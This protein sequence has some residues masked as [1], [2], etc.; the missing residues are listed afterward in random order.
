MEWV[1]ILLLS[2]GSVSLP[3]SFHSEEECL[4]AGEKAL[5]SCTATLGLF[6]RVQEVCSVRRYVCVAQPRALASPPRHR[7]PS[8]AR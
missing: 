2:A 4:G 8:L 7:A 6:D 5:P 1:L 3:R